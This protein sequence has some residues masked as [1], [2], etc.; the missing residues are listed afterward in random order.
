M[1]LLVKHCKSVSRCIYHQGFLGVCNRKWLAHSCRKINVSKGNLV[2]HSIIGKAR[3]LDSKNRAAPR[4]AGQ[5]AA[6]T[7]LRNFIVRTLLVL[8]RNAEA[9][10]G[11]SP[12][13]ALQTCC[14][15]HQNGVSCVQDSEFQA[16]SSVTSCILVARK[17]NKEN[18]PVLQWKVNPTFH[19]EPYSREP[20][21]IRKGSQR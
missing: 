18:F 20:P 14:C 17:L 4:E 12:P 3:K 13:R 8:T 10:L 21:N 5:I 9:A 2:D 15:C 19:L 6:Q 1:L 11:T 7:T 16:S